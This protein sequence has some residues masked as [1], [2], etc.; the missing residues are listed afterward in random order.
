MLSNRRLSVPSCL[1]VA[2][3]TQRTNFAACAQILGLGLAGSWK[4]MLGNYMQIAI[5]AF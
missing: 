2:G 1:F 5:P 4:G 3:K